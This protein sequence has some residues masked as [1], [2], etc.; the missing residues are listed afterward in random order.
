MEKVTLL[1][2]D[3]D[4]EGITKSIKK[5]K[6]KIEK[7]IEEAEEL[8]DELKDT[9]EEIKTFNKKLEELADK[10]KDASEEIKNIS[11]ALAIV[12]D[13]N[14]NAGEA[15]KRLSKMISNEISVYKDLV[16]QKRK[17]NKAIEK[18]QDLLKDTKKTH[19][20]YE[21]AIKKSA[22]EVRAFIKKQE[23]LKEGNKEI[24]KSLDQQVNKYAALTKGIKEPEQ[25]TKGFIGALKDAVNAGISFKG[26]FEGT[27]QIIS[28]L[29]ASLKL[30]S[31]S[32]QD[33]VKA[34]WAAVKGTEGISKAM[35]IAKAAF[36]SLGI[37]AIILVIGSLISYLTSTQEGINKVNKVLIPLKVVFQVLQTA[38]Q[39]FGEKIFNAFSNPKEAIV[40][41]WETIMENMVNRI[42]AVGDVFKAL[43]TIISSGF[44][45]GYKDLGNAFIKANTGIENGIDKMKGA[46]EKTVDVLSEAYKRG[47]EIAELQ[48]QLNSSEAA[49]IT[50]GATLN[51]QLEKQNQIAGDMNNSI[52]KREVA[53]NKAIKLQQEINKLES[54]RLDLQIELL[55]KKQEGKRLND[56]EKNEMANMIK[57]RTE[58]NANIAKTE[59]E[60]KQQ[61][62]AIYK[63]R[64]ELAIKQ[65][66]QELN[67]YI[68]QEGD[69]K[70]TLQ[71]TITYE[72]NLKEKRLSILDQELKAKKISKL[73]YEAESLRITH[74]Y[75][76]KI[77]NATVDNLTY[78]LEMYQAKNKSKID[79]ETLLTD[80]LVAEEENRQNQ[81]YAKEKEILDK[82]L[83]DGLISQQEYNLQKQ[84]LDD[85]Y[86]AKKKDLNNTYE[87]QKNDQKAAQQAAQL[88]IDLAN[89]S[90]EFER[91]KI[92]ETENYNA[93][94]AEYDERLKKKEITE[95]QYRQL[96]EKAEKEHTEAIKAIDKAKFNAK[97]DL[98]KST[99]GNIA[100]L[101]G[102]HTAV[103]K[104]AAIAE[105][106]INTY[107]AATAAYSA[108]SGITIVG[109]VLGAIA[110]AA[111]VAAG[112]ANVKK[113]VSVKTPKAKAE[114]GAVFTIGGNRHSMGGTKFYGEDGT[115]F[116]AEQGEKMFV[117]NR[118]ASAAIGPLLS[119]LNKQY[120]GV[121]LSNTSSY[122]AAG[123]QVLRAAAR[124]QQPEVPKINYDELAGKIGQQVAVAN[125]QL[126][127]PVVAV[128]DINYSQQS[129][130][131]VVTGANI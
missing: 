4:V 33:Y 63:E 13:S 76:E 85:E 52:S 83:A 72:G 112:L 27:L 41:L 1:Q 117:L 81:L 104:A 51:E 57:Q 37:G 6:E 56:D 36:V 119:D 48:E 87:Q 103:G 47:E 28:G 75:S 125:Q 15:F 90:D 96:N 64:L 42:T 67:L 62:K 113:I 120:G 79:S 30:S 108:L 131:E 68:A 100:S 70:K 93:Q 9:S 118:K 88:E 111:A 71:E 94:Q 77:A 69:K 61:R 49:Y 21:D 39:N 107:Q 26:E 110:A 74:E 109:P 129:Y 101:V 115:A 53:I 126:P 18:E 128:E 122:L 124:T 84:A 5:A 97:L 91:Q 46:Y 65:S 106:T 105:A 44:T 31:S 98:A 116:E 78:E 66:E 11:E 38:V 40:K 32:L 102:E 45:S 59:Y 80:Q 14:S 17:F 127:R 95:D 60:A 43:G 34:Q 7:L 8:Q 121:S 2:L 123:G 114:K 58:L 3:I 19:E 130:A 55:E 86:E 50:K 25:K 99:F 89:A 10:G 54:N 20:N 35:Q 24:V 82:R 92:Q 23:E 16:N 22:E 12:K 29:T 73:E